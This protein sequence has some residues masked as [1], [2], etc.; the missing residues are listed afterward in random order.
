ME[1]ETYYLCLDCRRIE[2]LEDSYHLQYRKEAIQVRKSKKRR[3][4]LMHLLDE[5]S[6]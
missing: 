3:F 4:C 2:S 1:G 6:R 5:N